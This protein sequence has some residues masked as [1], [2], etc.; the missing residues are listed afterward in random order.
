MIAGPTS[1]C[2]WEQLT[3]AIQTDAV[4]SSKIDVGFSFYGNRQR[5]IG[6]TT[7]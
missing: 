1:T 4:G 2:G 5:G 3:V 6:V 7:G